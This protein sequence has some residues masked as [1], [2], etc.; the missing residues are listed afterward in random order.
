MVDTD[1]ELIDALSEYTEPIATNTYNTT[2][3]I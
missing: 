2:Q 1:T 3:G